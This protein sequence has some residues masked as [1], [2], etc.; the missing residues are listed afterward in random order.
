MR[1]LN[2]RQYV[3]PREERPSYERMGRGKAGSPVWSLDNPMSCALA[4]RPLL[5]RMPRYP[6]PARKADGNEREE[7]AT[8]WQRRERR[9]RGEHCLD[10]LVYSGRF[11]PLRECRW[12]KCGRTTATPLA[13]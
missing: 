12:K 5:G 1:H 10:G 7:G 2:T 13:R 4:R 3:L 6:T 11:V 9:H 8:W